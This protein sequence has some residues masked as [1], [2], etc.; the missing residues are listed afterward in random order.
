MSTAQK[1]NVHVWTATVDNDYEPWCAPVVGA[2]RQQA[3]DGMLAYLIEYLCEVFECEDEPKTDWRAFTDV[4]ELVKA[5]NAE[6]WGFRSM[7]IESSIHTID[8]NSI[9]Y[10]TPICIRKDTA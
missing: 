9:E 8:A 2:T 7:E 1:I 6:E 10:T 3:H 5:A 4:N